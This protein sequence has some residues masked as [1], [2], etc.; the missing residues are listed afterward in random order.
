MNF[1]YSAI[2]AWAGIVAAFAAI[3]AVWAEGR[4][5]RY[6]QGL[7]ILLN[8]SSEFNGETFKN[9]R[10]LVCN[11][12]LKE[13]NG[14]KVTKKEKEIF[15]VGAYEILDHFEFL[16]TLLHQRTL[17]KNL[18]SSNYFYWVYRYWTCLDKLILENRQED[19]TIWEE[20]EWLYNSLR[21]FEK[22]D[23]GNKLPA[24]TKDDL[25]SFYE[26]ESSLK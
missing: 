19:E 26:Y 25:I 21:K 6:A 20:A 7:D 11:Y 1:D 17:D 24:I 12:L 2:S 23:R 13:I 18:V 3:F 4:R 8:L 14:K 5:S 16:G 9:S 22:R 10:R 15:E